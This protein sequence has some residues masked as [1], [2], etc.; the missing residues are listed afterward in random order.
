MTRVT[1]ENEY[2]KYSVEIPNRDATLDE[3]MNWAILPALKA[4]GYN[5]EAVDEYFSV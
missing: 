5:S 3:V 4:A 1:I 2:G